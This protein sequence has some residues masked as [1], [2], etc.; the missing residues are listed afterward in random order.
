MRRHRSSLALNDGVEKCVG[1][2]ILKA[3]FMLKLGY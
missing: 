3:M 1:D 2:K